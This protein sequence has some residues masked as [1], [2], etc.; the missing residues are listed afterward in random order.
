MHGHRPISFLVEHQV[1]M[2]F[3]AREDACGNAPVDEEIHWDVQPTTSPISL[4]ALMGAKSA[5]T[6]RLR[7]MINGKIVHVLVDNKCTCNFIHSKT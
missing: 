2:H 1:A 7:E 5:K 3:H 4:H 6:I